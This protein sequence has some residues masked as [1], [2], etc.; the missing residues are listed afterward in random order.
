M[1]RLGEDLEHAVV[2][3]Q[4]KARRDGLQLL[5]K[6]R[7]KIELRR[8]AGLLTRRHADLRSNA[9][10]HVMRR[11]LSGSTTVLEKRIGFLR[12]RNPR[13]K[14]VLLHHR[15]PTAGDLSLS[16]ADLW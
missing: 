5:G 9:A 4:L 8:A 2:D 3:G 15:H 1:Q 11:A 6:L 10:N 7:P 14:E 13:A 12:R 16:A